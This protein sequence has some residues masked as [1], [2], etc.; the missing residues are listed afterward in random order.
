TS[1]SETGVI[2]SGLNESKIS[3]ILQNNSNL[4]VRV[5]N[6]VHN[7]FEIIGGDA[8]TLEQIKSNPDASIEKN[9]VFK[10][11][12]PDTKSKKNIRLLNTNN[13]HNASAPKNPFVEFIEVNQGLRLGGELLDFLQVCKLDSR[14][15]PELIIESN[16]VENKK[17]PELLFN[18][19]SSLIL[20]SEKSKAKTV[21]KK[22][23]FLWIVTANDS[24][25]L[26]P[27]AFGENLVKY[28]P[29]ATGDYLY[30][31][32]AK[33]SLNVCQINLKRFYVTTNDKFKPEI[34]LPDSFA[35]HLDP[36]TF[37]HVFYTGA[38]E[39]WKRST[40]EN[41]TIGII[42]SGVNYNHSALS[43]NIFANAKEIPNNGIDDDR[44]GFID[45]AVGYD[46]GD[47]DSFAFD[48]YGHGSHV[49][50]IAASQVF[51]A[52]RKAKI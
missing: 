11:N 42:D 12:D 10:W 37:W 49:S 30:S 46:F 48:D 25:E 5:I 28:L 20:K 34:P 1:N 29:D 4:K 21:D 26:T 40:G 50:G 41:I 32:V 52:A 7:I 44:N 36:N 47:D 24:S 39:G 6:P 8:S 16:Q 27:Q 14:T 9:Q 51:G 15:A 45:D 19:G 22:L 17:K 35:E 43:P 33:D 18:L 2:V 13:K 3:K 31:V 38:Y 23:K